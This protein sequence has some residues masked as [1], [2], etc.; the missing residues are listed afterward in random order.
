MS[1]KQLIEDIDTNHD[2]FIDYSEFIA[3]TENK[4]ELL[5]DDNL[6]IAFN[7]ID[8]VRFILNLIG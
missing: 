8:K 1:M 3:A 6:K 7:E 5:T 2:G 4:K